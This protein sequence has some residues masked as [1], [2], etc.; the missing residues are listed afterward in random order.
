MED[1]LYIVLL[2]WGSFTWLLPINVAQAKLNDTNN[3]F[4]NAYL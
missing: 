3:N 4:A 1:W 2:C